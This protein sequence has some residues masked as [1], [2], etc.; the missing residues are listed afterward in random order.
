MQKWPSNLFS[1]FS[2][3]SDVSSDSVFVWSSGMVRILGVACMFFSRSLYLFFHLAAMRKQS[4]GGRVNDVTPSCSM[5]QSIDRS[6][7][8]HN[9]RVFFHF[10]SL[11]FNLLS[12]LFLLL[13]VLEHFL[14]FHKTHFCCNSRQLFG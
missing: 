4:R 9:E 13:F 12:F 5:D 2:F 14:R 3:K 1:M 11:L 6:L 7:V 8:I 10:Y